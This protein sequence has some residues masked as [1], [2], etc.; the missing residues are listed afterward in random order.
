MDVFD[1]VQFKKQFRFSKTEFRV[2]LSNML[3]ID[4]GKLV[5]NVG[6]PVMIRRIGRKP[7]D[8]VQ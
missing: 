3:D 4:G 6:L 5:D 1:E 2:I 8:F 7:R